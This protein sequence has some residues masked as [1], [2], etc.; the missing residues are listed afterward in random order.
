MSGQIGQAVGPGPDGSNAS[1]CVCVRVS[2]G[3]SLFMVPVKTTLLPLRLFSGGNGSQRFEPVAFYGP[4][5][6]PTSRETMP[7]HHGERLRPSQYRSWQ[8]AGAKYVK[9]EEATT[10][11]A[12]EAQS[13]PS[14]QKASVSD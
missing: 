4:L 9:L 10:G 12:S 1:F 14:H 2:A 3:A 13:R 7:R 6:K 11:A 8:R 5:P